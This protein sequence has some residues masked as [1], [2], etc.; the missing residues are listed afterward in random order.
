MFIIEP[1]TPM[2]TDTVVS[3]AKPISLDIWLGRGKDPVEKV[4]LYGCRPSMTPEEESPGMLRL[5]LQP[6]ENGLVIAWR[7]IL[8]RWVTNLEAMAIYTALKKEGWAECIRPVVSFSQM[9]KLNQ[10][11]YL[12]LGFPTP[13]SPKAG[14]DATS[15]AREKVLRDAADKE[16]R[17]A[18]GQFA[19]MPLEQQD[20]Y[21]KRWDAEQA[22]RRQ[23]RSFMDEETA[24]VL[25]QF[26]PNKKETPLAVSGGE[27]SAPAEASGSLSRA[28]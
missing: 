26:H 11:A 18:P 5:V 6:V 12:A 14:V 3:G 20:D 21:R 9:G 27:P 13:E 23:V 1:P 7:P 16:L 2:F 25:Q 4:R 28:S 8:E 19:A 10:G 15:I 24:A 17:L 22:R